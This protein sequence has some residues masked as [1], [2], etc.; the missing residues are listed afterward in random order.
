MRQREK[1]QWLKCLDDSLLLTSR[2]A[3][4]G[5]NG[6]RNEIQSP[7]PPPGSAT[8]LP[9]VLSPVPNTNVCKVPSGPDMPPIQDRR[10]GARAGSSFFFFLNFF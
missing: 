4:L 9:C 8:N 10:W 7:G 1:E 5:E 6:P 2:D 3:T